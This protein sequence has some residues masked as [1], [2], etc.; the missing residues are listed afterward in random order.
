M[1]RALVMRGNV[2]R[3]YMPRLPFADDTSLW[4]HCHMVYEVV[5]GDSRLLKHARSEPLC[6]ESLQR[7]NVEAE[8]SIWSKHKKFEQFELGKLIFRV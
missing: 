3:E 1:E 4:Y 2:G 8:P 5:G 6:D 7:G